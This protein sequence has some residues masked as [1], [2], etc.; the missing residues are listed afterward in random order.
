MRASCG[1]TTSKLGFRVH[2]NR[3]KTTEIGSA[4]QIEKAFD[5]KG[6]F[7]TKFLYISAQ[8]QPLDKF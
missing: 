3:I 4:D 1:G 6:I 2:T 8:P 5:R 7:Q